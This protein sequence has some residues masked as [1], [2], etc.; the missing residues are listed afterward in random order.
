MQGASSLVIFF[1]SS[2]KGFAAWFYPT[3]SVTA[4]YF[5]GVHKKDVFFVWVCAFT[6]TMEYILLQI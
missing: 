3:F 1:K 4:W 2:S 5:G 6:L